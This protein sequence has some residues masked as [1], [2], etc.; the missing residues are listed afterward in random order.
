MSSLD[1]IDFSKI[2]DE[3]FMC[4]ND[5]NEKFRSSPLSELEE[6]FKQRADKYFTEK[7]RY[8]L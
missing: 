7:C 5:V 1:N 2:T 4:V 3:Q 8:E 6:I